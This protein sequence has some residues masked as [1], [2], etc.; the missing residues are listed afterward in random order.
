[1]KE[2]AWGLCI[3]QALSVARKETELKWIEA[4]R[5][6]IGTYRGK[7]RSG[8]SFRSISI[9]RLGCCHLGAFFIAQTFSAG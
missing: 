9:W 2:T 7:T 5:E 1:M 6:F 8:F 3:S 4:I